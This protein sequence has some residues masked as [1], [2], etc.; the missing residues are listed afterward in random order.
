MPLTR[1]LTGSADR[2]SA[3]STATVSG[4][5][6]AAAAAA[7]AAVAVML[8][9]GGT[10]LAA[11]ASAAAASAAVATKPAPAFGTLDT[12]PGTAGT[13]AKAGLSQAMFE[14]NWGAFEPR[15]G[16]FDASYLAGLR[17]DLAAYQ[18]QHMHVTLGLGTQNA[19]AWVLALNNGT[20][21]NQYGTK[22][23][24]ANLVFSAAVRAAATV[25]LTRVAADFRLS[26]FWAIRLTSGGNAEMLY[27]AGGTYWAFGPSALTGKGLPAGISRNPYPAYRPGQPG[28][29][30][31]PAQAANWL[32][33]YVGGLDNVTNWQMTTLKHLGFAGYYE[34]VT[35]GSGERPDGVA[36]AE[37]AGLPANGGTIGVGAVWYLYYAK[38]PVKTK[39]IAYISSV[40]DQSGGNDSCK[41]ADTALPLTSSAM[42]SWSATRWITRIAA[43]NHLLAGGENPGLGMPASLDSFYL[44]TT[45]AGMMTSSLN[46]ARTCGFTVFY[47][48]HDIHLHDGSIPFTNYITAIKASSGIHV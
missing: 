29:V 32:S 30:I 14:L 11:T 27:P 38:L 13:E 40:A 35:P 39:V 46:Q 19:P 42:D 43:Q 44:N 47:W 9:C 17:S 2:M 48:A 25:Y 24:E 21:V 3:G 6:M 7:T 15:Q 22:S 8:A 18:A 23:T 33:W 20:Y 5:V 12:Q 10:A 45:T 34:T 16:V 37:K 41:A 1:A 31:T 4:R 26:S 36:A 28:S